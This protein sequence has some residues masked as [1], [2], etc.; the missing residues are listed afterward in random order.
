MWPRG[1]YKRERLGSGEIAYDDDG[2][3][4]FGCGRG[5]VLRVVRGHEN[6]GG[7]DDVVF[8]A[9]RGGRDT[10]HPSTRLHYSYCRQI[11]YNW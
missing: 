10:N 5:D 9:D 1:L 11:I 7:D 2:G 4:D 8:H 6:D 3:R